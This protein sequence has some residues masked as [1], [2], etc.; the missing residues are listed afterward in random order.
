MTTTAPPQPPK[1]PM[2]AVFRYNQEHMDAYRKENPSKKIT[3]VTSELSARYSK[4]SEKEKQK[5]IDAY[6]KANEAYKKV[7]LPDA[8]PERLR[9]EARQSPAQ[10]ESQI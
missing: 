1:R 2:N 10:E 6:D 5:Y 7:R 4:L 8:E 3:E 9:R